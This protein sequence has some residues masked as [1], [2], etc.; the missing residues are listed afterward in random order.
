MFSLD[1]TFHLYGQ[2]MASNFDGVPKELSLMILRDVLTSPSGL[3]TLVD[4]P[5]MKPKRFKIFTHEWGNHKVISL[6]I[7]RTC[8]RFYGECRRLLWEQNILDLNS[9]FREINRIDMLWVIQGVGDNVQS[10]QL[11]IGIFDCPHNV[12]RVA[13]LELGTLKEFGSWRNLKSITLIS[14]DHWQECCKA[15]LDFVAILHGDHRKDTPLARYLELFQT[16]GGEGGYLGHLERKII[17]NF[18]PFAEVKN[19][20]INDYLN[21]GQLEELET[22]WPEE[23]FQ[24]LATSFGGDLILNGDVYHSDRIQKE[25][26]FYALWDP[27]KP[28]SQL[29]LLAMEYALQRLEVIYSSSTKWERH[30]IRKHLLGTTVLQVPKEDLVKIRAGLK[31]WFGYGPKQLVD[32]T[33]KIIEKNPLEIEEWRGK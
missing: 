21:P 2:T 19:Q 25:R 27:A 23:M 14:R 4:F 33:K 16:A 20:N 18:G 10:I 24:R 32:L 22:S 6:S 11:E 15:M 5:L 13:G 3:I 8:K 31:N 29:V 26:I 30:E 7:L 12:A 9:L 1:I 28:S 17:F